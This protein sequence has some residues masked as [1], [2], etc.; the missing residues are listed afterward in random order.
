MKDTDLLMTTMSSEEY[1]IEDINLVSLQKWL[2]DYYK[3][4]KTGEPFSIS[5]VQGYVVRGKLPSYL[6]GHVIQI[7]TN[8]VKGTKSYSIL[9]TI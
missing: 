8:R 4:K 2:N 1:L 9:R 3:I 7:S 5:D 6:G